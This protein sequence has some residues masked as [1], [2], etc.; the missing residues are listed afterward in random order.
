MSFDPTYEL[1][2]QFLNC[3]TL[4]EAQ[5]LVAACIDGEI[6]TS[7]HNP[8]GV[9][10][11]VSES[12]VSIVKY[13]PNELIGNSAYDYFHP[14]DFQT[15]LKSHAKISIK[16]EIDRVKYR[17]IT[18]TKEVL[19]VYTQSRQIK[20]PSGQEFILAITTRNGE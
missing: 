15:I 13:K 12:S 20:D 11:Q 3:S 7:I 6:M 4:S 16:P 19:N 1:V 9:Y 14:E 2:Q 8:N 10:I 18:K 17:I 5:E